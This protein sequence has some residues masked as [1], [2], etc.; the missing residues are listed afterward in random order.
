MEHQI[1][2]MNKTYNELCKLKTFTERLEYLRLQETVG[3]FTFGCFRYLNQT[4]YKSPE[5]KQFRY[6]IF[7]RD[8]GCDLGL[9]DHPI[10]DQYY[11]VH[12]IAPI[13]IDDIRNRNIEV[14]LN[15]DNVITTSLKTHNLIH[16]GGEA[17]VTPELVIRSPGDT[18]PWKK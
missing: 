16:Y 11:I 6:K 3:D 2:T 5:W 1:L 10:F 18:C 8:E 7:I 9:A 4:F 12:H 15:E 13:S 17:I 14:L